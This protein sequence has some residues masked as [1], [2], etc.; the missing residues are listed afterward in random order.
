MLGTNLN[1]RSDSYPRM[2]RDRPLAAS[3][4]LPCPSVPLS[5]ERVDGEQ[6][7]K[8]PVGAILPPVPLGRQPTR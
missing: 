1:C 3:Q 7:L 2:A 4:V 6:L 5:A 8:T